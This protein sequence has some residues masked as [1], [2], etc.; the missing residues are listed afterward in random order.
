MVSGGYVTGKNASLTGLPDVTN[1]VAPSITGTAQVGQTLTAH[2]GTWGPSPVTTTRQW[3][4]DGEEIEGAT[5]VTFVPTSGQIG[6]S[7][8][9]QVTGSKPGHNSL[10]RES[11]YTAEVTA[12]SSAIVAATP[13]ITGTPKVG[14]TLTAN[15]NASSWT[16]SS[17]VAFTYEWMRGSTPISGATSS[18]YTPVAADVGQTIKV[19]VTGTKAGMTPAN[20]TS[21]PTA[22]VAAADATPMTPGTVT[23]SGTAKVGQ[24]LTAN[25]GTWSPALSGAEYSYQ[26][27]RGSTEIAG[28]TSKTYVPVAADVGQTL[29]VKVT[30]T[31]AG[32]TSANATSAA[33][34]AVAAGTMTPGTVTVSG[35]AA[36]G[37]TLTANEGTWSPA[38]S[39]AEY[40]YQWIRGS[41]EIAGATSKTYVP[42]A[43]DAGQTL[44]VKVTGTKAGYTSAN[45]TSAATAPVTGTMT[46]GTVTVSGTA[47]V[48]QTLTANEG[49]WTPALSGAEYTYQWIRGAST[50]IA[51][52]TSKTYVPVAADVGQTLK[53]KVTGTKAGYT[54]ANATSAATSAVAAGTMT[55]GTVTVSGTAAIGST[56]TANEGTWS[57]AL[58]GA[59]YSYQWIRG[60]STEIAGATSKTYVPVAADAGQTLKVKVTG[61]KAGYTSANATSPAT[62][63]VVAALTPGTVTVTG[64]PRLGQTLTANEGTW[65]P[66]GVSFEYQWI[67]GSTVIVGA[68]SK[69]YVTVVADLGQTLKVKVTGTKSGY[70][71]ANATSAATAA[72]KVAPSMSVSGKGAKKKA[73]LTITV[74]A[75]GVVPTGRVTIKLGSKTLKTVTLKSGKASVTLTKQ[76]KG[77]RKYTIIYGGDAK[78][79]AK[80]VTKTVKVK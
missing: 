11:D 17:G 34:S 37:S 31:K 1:S 59:E 57:P 48:G 32:Y 2:D 67:R 70:T 39:G 47:K 36:I 29:K 26:W 63:A 61:T 20:A 49:T 69:T 22:A 55:P 80:T 75:T 25:E 14:V 60:A 41:T 16:P 76:K 72:V 54:S 9:L 43:A 23:V 40:S 79:L 50:E 18:T 38:L 13:T 65:T 3:L 62:S 7:I 6:R 56:L 53:V 24:T 45:A 4:A 52:A 33:T 12:P 74:K 19:K 44:K 30:G 66:T 68:T 71:S 10:Q 58:S 46:A 21:A 78:V 42:V 64:T 73:T 5:G 28:A 77:N 15:P 35:T 8:S 51:G 27:I